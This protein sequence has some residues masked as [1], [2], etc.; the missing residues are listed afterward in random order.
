MQASAALQRDGHQKNTAQTSRISEL[1][2]LGHRVQSADCVSR[3]IDLAAANEFDLAISDLGLPDGSGLQL[4]Q[5]LRARHGMSGIALS[6]YGME[7]DI[8]RSREAGFSHHLI[9]PITPDGLQ[10]AIL[11]VLSQHAHS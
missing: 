10:A 4:M 5:H 2:Q 11:Q 9:K 8:Q 1:E 7:I 3:A 6:G